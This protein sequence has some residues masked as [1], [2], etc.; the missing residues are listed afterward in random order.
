M[1]N[2]I[3]EEAPVFFASRRNIFQFISGCIFF[4]IFFFLICLLLYGLYLVY[5][6]LILLFIPVGF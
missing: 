2:I 1:K 5:C 3:Q 6:L 4:C